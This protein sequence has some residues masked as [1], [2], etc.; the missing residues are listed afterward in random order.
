MGREIRFRTY[1]KELAIVIPVQCINFNCTTVEVRLDEGDFW[2]LD[3]EEVKLMQFTNLLDK[4]GIPIYEGDIVKISYISPFDNE[5]KSHIWVVEY[6]T[7]MYW[8]RDVN[9]MNQY[10]S[11]LF[12]KFTRIEVIGNIYENPEFI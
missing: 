3:F 11:F 1:I 9:K 12:L 4:N 10:D 5:E 6:E 7:G 8:L 2:E